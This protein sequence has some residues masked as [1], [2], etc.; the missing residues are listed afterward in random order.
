MKSVAL[1]HLQGL[2]SAIDLGAEVGSGSTG[3][4]EVLG[5]DWLDERAEDKLG[6]T[7]SWESEPEDNDELECVVEWEP[8]DSADGALKNGQEREDH[9]VG[10]PLSV[11]R[12]ANS[13]Q[14]LK[15]VVTWDDKSSNICEEL[16]TNI[17]EDEEEVGCDQSEK[18]IDLGDRS[19]LL[20]VVEKRVLGKLLINL[21]NVAL[22]FVLER[23]HG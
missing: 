2:V 11:I 3:S 18:G 12:L 6:T 15:R 8:I 19:L 13:E 20:K 21:G 10:E 5:E 17:E 9:P 23:R 22:R 1:S 16:P 7:S 14:G 4:G